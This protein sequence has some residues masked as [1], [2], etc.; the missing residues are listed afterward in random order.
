MQAAESV[1]GK[2]MIKDKFAKNRYCYLFFYLLNFFKS[3]NN[4]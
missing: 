4:L 1:A 3:Q 2:T